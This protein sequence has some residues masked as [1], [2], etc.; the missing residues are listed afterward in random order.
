MNLNQLLNLARPYRGPLGLLALVG[1]TAASI[2]L[3]VPWLAGSLLGGIVEGSARG[4][5]QART[6]GLLLLCL[7]GATVLNVAASLLSV[8]IDTRI[9]AELRQQMF[10][11]VQ[12]LPI[13]FHE[14]R[15]KGDTLALMTYE[16]WRL[17]Q[18]LT[19]TLATTPARLLTTV[20]AVAAMFKIDARLAMVVPLLIPIF[21]LVLKLVGRSLRGLAAAHQHAEAALV[22]LA[23]ES[24]EMLPATKAFT[25]EQI[26]SARFRTA[27]EEVS[28]LSIRQGQINALLDPLLTLI[29]AVAAIGVIILAGKEVLGAQLDAGQRLSFIF[30]AGLLTRPVSALAHIYGEVQVARG[31]LERMQSVLDQPIEEIGSNGVSGWRASGAVE[32]RD[33]RFAYPG[34]D[35]LFDN[36][37]LSID[38][39]E[40]VALLG[41]NGAGK[42]ALVNLLLRYYDP[43]DGEILL[44][45]RPIAKLNLADL[46]RQ[47]GLVPQLPL[48]FNASIRDNIAFGAH[49]AI[50]EQVEQAAATAQ[51]LDF[52]R[53]LPHDFDTMIGDRGVQLSGG[54]RQRIALARALIKDPPILILDEATSMF[55]LDGEEKFIANCIEALAG[56]TVIMITHRPAILGLADRIVEVGKGRVVRSDPVLR[57]SPAEAAE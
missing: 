43:Q 6:V 17:G 31:T 54:Q 2:S 26:A 9:L 34:R 32:F 25:R 39:G 4:V 3:L 45:G 57:A 23:E 52:I 7:G 47:I 56:R 55:D 21:Y 41:P 27:T 33:V 53:A 30:Y 10:E 36:F 8:R 44:D 42:T 29:T 13:G 22:A 11:H 48:L 24:L 49:G 38:A 18:F 37:S 40:R 46:R 35:R 14:S 51:A 1:A 5:E 19:R 16:V 20:G 50:D 15:G 12:H 28:R